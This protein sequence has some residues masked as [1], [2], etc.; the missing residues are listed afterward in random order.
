MEDSDDHEDN[1]PLNNNVNDEKDMEPEL[2]ASKRKKSSSVWN[3]F[4]LVESRI[5][6]SDCGKRFQQRTSTTSLRYHLIH[7]HDVCDVI[8]PRPR[9]FDKQAA[10]ELLARMF[11]KNCLPLRLVDDAEFRKFVY[12]L[13]PSWKLCD[14]RRLTTILLPQLQ[15]K[16]EGVIRE[17]LA[18]I[19]HYSISIDSWTS[20]ANTIFLALSAHGIS[21]DWKLESFMLDII[22][23]N[24]A[25]TGEYI[26]ALVR[27]SLGKW[28]ISH[29][30]IVSGT[31]DGAA[32]VKKAIKTDLSLLWLYCVAHMLNRS[33][34]I[35]LSKVQEVKLL[36]K[37]A[38]A[39][40]K[41]FRR[42][43]KAAST[44]KEQQERLELPTKKMTL[45]TKTRWSSAYKMIKRLL[46]SRPALSAT[47]ATLANTPTTTRKPPPHDLSSTEWTQLSQLLEVLCRTLLSN[48]QAQ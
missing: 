9:I 43:P 45:E 14:R 12:Y 11:A 39:I 5:V 19:K 7:V 33:I 2:P 42:S 17:R 38:K 25:E 1:D 4:H 36:L 16:L 34:Q 44:L 23:V 20:L 27:E 28:N 26:A 35:G 47:L 29:S 30:R 37:K 21:K 48:S 41:Y 15:T 13:E 8:D 46:K 40:C 3:H 32:N 24:K 18:H 31:S 6:C 22:T 10:E